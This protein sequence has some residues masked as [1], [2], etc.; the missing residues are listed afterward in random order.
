MTRCS[1]IYFT[2]NKG[3]RYLLPLIKAAG[4][5]LAKIFKSLNMF[6]GGSLNNF[7]NGKEW[8]MVIDDDQKIQEKKGSNKSL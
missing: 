2:V 8:C 3:K 4:T 1:K 6:F 7:L 5:Y